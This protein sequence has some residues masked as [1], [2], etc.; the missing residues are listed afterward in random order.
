MGILLLLTMKY[1]KRYLNKQKTSKS[2]VYNY[3][4]EDLSLE[5]VIAQFAI[6][7]TDDKTYQ[8]E[9]KTNTI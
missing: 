3:S 9:N 2:I 4:K 1:S 7:A 5:A 8:V 6:T